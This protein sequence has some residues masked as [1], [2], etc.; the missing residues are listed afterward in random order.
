MEYDL[1]FDRIKLTTV[2]LFTILTLIRYVIRTMKTKVNLKKHRQKVEK[3][4]VE[5]WLIFCV[6]HEKEIF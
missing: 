2:Q 1:N 6:R 4:H 5:T 3:R